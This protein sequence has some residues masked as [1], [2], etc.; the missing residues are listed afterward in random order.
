MKRITP[1]KLKAGFLLFVFSLNIVLVFAC[2]I[3]INMGY[4]D[5]HHEDEKVIVAHSHDKTHNKEEKVETSIN[6]NKAHSHDEIA[7]NQQSEKSK[8]DCCTDEA[9]KFAQ[10]DKRAPLTPEFSFHP[11]FLVTFFS[12][13]YNF[14]V[15]ASDT[16]FS[17]SK[18]FVRGHHPPIPKIRIAIQSFQI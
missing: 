9:I 10:I 5:S 1:I 7:G 18:Y 16:L 3:G 13:P 12:N 17:A 2:F 6:H 4:N 8:D 14:D 11:V 15:L